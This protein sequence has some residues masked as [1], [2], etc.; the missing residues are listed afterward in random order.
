MGEHRGSH[1]VRVSVGSILETGE[2]HF[3][4]ET[5]DLSE[6]GILLH[7][8]QAF[9][10]G[11]QLRLAFG[12]SPDLPNI[13]AE[14]VV[15]WSETGKGVGVE[16]ISLSSESKQLLQQFLQYRPGEEAPS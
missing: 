2:L 8:R 13:T 5:G 1:R 6:T 12:L 14:G 16:F 9:P 3:F 15:R 7:T 10:V 11:T 4:A